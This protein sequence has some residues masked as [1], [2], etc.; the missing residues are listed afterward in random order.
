M[1]IHKWKMK[2]TMATFTELSSKAHKNLKVAPNAQINFAAKQHMINLN[3]AELA[4]AASSM[5]IFVSRTN[6]TG[7]WAFAAMTS[8]E[9]EVNLFVENETWTPVFNPTSLRTH[10]L[11][12]M[13]SKTE[14]KTFTVGFNAQTKSLTEEEGT[15]LFNDDGKGTDYLG[16]VTKILETEL[17]Y[18]KQTYEFGQVLENMNLLKAIDLKVQYKNGTTNIIQGLHTINE[19]AFQALSGENLAQ[20]NSVGYLT[21]IHAMPM[22]IFQLNV[23]VNKHNAIASKEPIASVKIE[24]S[25]A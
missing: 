23:L 5:P 12:L 2:H 19:E 16:E 17:Q 20:L 11:Q 1:Q 25:K 13:P 10:P 6:G 8:F 24:P 3:V 21:P 7:S 9:L 14:E 4:A 15:A 18:R 22:S